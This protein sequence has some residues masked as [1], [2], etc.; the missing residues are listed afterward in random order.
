MERSKG[1]GVNIFLTT[2]YQ[3]MNKSLKAAPNGTYFI[4]K[5]QTGKQ[6]SEIANGQVMEMFQESWCRV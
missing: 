5:T 4:E 1:L 6:T 3:H 2:T